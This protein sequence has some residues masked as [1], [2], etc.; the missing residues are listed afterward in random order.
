MC[1]D[2]HKPGYTN[3][4]DS[5]TDILG[6]SGNKNHPCLCFRDVVLGGIINIL[7]TENRSAYQLS[8]LVD[9]VYSLR[10][11]IWGF[12]PSSPKTVKMVPDA[13]QH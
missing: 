2:E 1:P 11:G 10:L 5:L 3:D 8:G 7:I 4:V 12:D 6:G 13:S 9:R